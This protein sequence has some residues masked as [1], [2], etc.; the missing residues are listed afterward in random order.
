M[1]EITHQGPVHYSFTSGHGQALSIDEI[2]VLD[3]ISR[4]YQVRLVLGR[5]H[6]YLFGTA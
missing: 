2:R 4:G 1:E 5:L 3:G 6:T